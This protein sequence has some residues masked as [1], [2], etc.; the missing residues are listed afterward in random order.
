MNRKFLTTALIV[1]IASCAYAQD[2][3]KAK[4]EKSP[5]HG[6]WVTVKHGNRSVETWVVY[7][8]AKN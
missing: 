3:A 6:E 4:L 7:P 1:L 5:R 8:E 2:W